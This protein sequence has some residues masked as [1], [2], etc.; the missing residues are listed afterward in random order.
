MRRAASDVLHDRILVKPPREA[1]FGLGPTDLVVTTGEEFYYYDPKGFHDHHE[2]TWIEELVAVAARH[3]VTP[4][5]PPS[6]IVIQSQYYGPAELFAAL[7]RIYIRTRRPQR[8]RLAGP[9]MS[10]LPLPSDVMDNVTRH[11][12]ERDRHA[13]SATCRAWCALAWDPL[14]TRAVSDDVAEHLGQELRL[15]TNRIAEFRPTVYDVVGAWTLTKWWLENH[16]A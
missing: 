11:L 6:R 12:G 14:V 9:A 16:A 3:L 8:P 10:D 5:L 7:V 2:L 15:L 1:S 13:A 4:M